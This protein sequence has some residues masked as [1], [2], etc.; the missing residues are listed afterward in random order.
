[1]STKLIVIV[2]GLVLIGIGATLLFFT[3]T[4]TSQPSV[5]QPQEQVIAESDT[6]VKDSTIAEI[7]E[8]QTS[9]SDGMNDPDAATRVPPT[10][11]AP[12]AAQVPNDRLH[13]EFVNQYGHSY[14][15]MLL[16][17]NLMGQPYLLDALGENVPGRFKFTDTTGILEFNEPIRPGTYS[18]GWFSGSTIGSDARNG[19]TR[20][21]DE[22][23]YEFTIPDT[24]ERQVFR[25]EVDQTKVTYPSS[26][27]S[28]KL[29]VVNEVGT[30]LQ[31]D[32]WNT[33]NGVQN[34][35]LYNPDGNK[36][37][38]YWQD[39][40]QFMENESAPG[41]YRLEIRK[42][43]YEPKDVEFVLPD[44]ST[45]STEQLMAA[46]PGIIDLGTITLKKI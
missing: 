35:T 34:T 44:V 20:H 33:W 5:A 1:M 3:A 9:A 11:T 43:G 32:S 30:S 41:T 4:N 39:G 37:G 27:R 19:I 13:V 14:R 24:P 12:A 17:Y 15:G 42:E 8:P 18:V 21:Y 7:E 22:G 23:L 16:S 26:W 2:V 29:K 46:T 36:V 6:P 10:A 45:W 25:V 38:A 28:V 31:L 40:V